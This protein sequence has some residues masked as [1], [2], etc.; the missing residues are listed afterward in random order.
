MLDDIE[1][2][3]G[4]PGGEQRLTAVQDDTLERALH[5]LGGGR[6]EPV[7][8]RALWKA[9]RQAQP[10]DRGKARSVG[11]REPRRPRQTC[12]RAS[13]RLTFMTAAGILDLLALGVA[14]PTLLSDLYAVTLLPPGRAAS[15]HVLSRLFRR[16][17]RWTRY[18]MSPVSYFAVAYLLVRLGWLAFTSNLTSAWKA[19]EM[20]S[21]PT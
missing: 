21:V 18:L 16:F 3:R 20:P 12:V 4:I 5:E 9:S 17:D 11:E 2:V 8:K 6:V 15:S 14:L 7:E 13:F 1:S 19:A 10:P